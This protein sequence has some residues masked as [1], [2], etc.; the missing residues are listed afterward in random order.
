[1]GGLIFSGL[2]HVLNLILNVLQIMVF[3]SVLINLL[4][5]DPRNPIVNFIE[6]AT[7]PVYRPIRRWTSRIPG[8]FDWAPFAV[9]LLIV[10]V[11]KTLVT[12]LL[13]QGAG[14]SG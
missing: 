4:G 8:P 6:R 11:Q 12:W 5:A 3:V 9:L 13:I 1:M 10:F 7:E 2:G 14:Y